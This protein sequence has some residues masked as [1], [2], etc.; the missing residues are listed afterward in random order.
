MIF[1]PSKFAG[2]RPLAAAPLASLA[3]AQAPPSE[4]QTACIITC[5]NYGRFLAQCLDSCLRQTAPFA[6]IIVVDDASTDDTR[7]VTAKYAKS[8][9]K[10]LRT[11]FRNYSAARNAGYRATP[12]TSHLLFV[13]AD[14]WLADNY[15][16]CLRRGFR[17]ANVGACYGNLL[18]CRNGQTLGLS[19]SVY[20]FR[21]GCLEHRNM[22][23]ACSLMRRDTFEQVGLWPEAGDVM[24]D[25]SLWLRFQRMGWR[26][27]FC[28][29][30]VLHYRV[31]E[32]QM[33]IKW[34]SKPWEI[35]E[36]APKE[37]A[38][39]ALVTLF[40][41]RAWALPSYTRFL[42]DLRWNK[43]NIVLVAVD[44]SGS[45]EFGKKLEAMLHGSGC[46]HVR[47]PDAI[48]AVAGVPSE[49]FAAD[50]RLRQQHNY[51][52]AVQMARLYATAR[53]FVPAAATHVWTI[54]DD[55]EPPPDALKHLMFGLYRFPQA[56]MV[57]GLARSRFG[58][59][60]IAWDNGKPF[61]APPPGEYKEAT[62][63]GFLCALFPR[64][65]WDA[66]AFKP[67]PGVPAGNIAYDHTAC[68]DIRNMGRKV[69]IAGSVLCKH[70]QQDG[71]CR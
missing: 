61:E 38:L 66:L 53:Q 19:K 33:S 57:G 50:P 22:A 59:R 45:V 70:W 23:D 30:A 28:P 40:S 17:D 49:Q 2:G 7:A 52:L 41:G 27:Q 16:E 35:V 58:A 5:H 62:E 21:N 32:Q 60:W 42:Q 3:P 54:E 71:T 48:R 56:G 29:E 6:Y 9:V 1:R 63:T 18:H 31:H 47:V 20:A 15:V 4:Q 36:A 64:S 12:P 26:M 65:I 11:E 43:R 34:R 37:S 25:W 68:R 55:I 46:V 14:N 67:G 39:F 69:L 13:D 8:G 44:N 24:S 10:Y 51:Q